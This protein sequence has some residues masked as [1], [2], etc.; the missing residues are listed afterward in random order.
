MLKVTQLTGFGSR[1]PGVTVTNETLTAAAGS[2]S[3]TGTAASL[4][5]AGNKLLAAGAGSYSL[6]GTAATIT[7]STS[8]SAEATAFL[9]R[10]SGLDTTHTNAYVALING[11]VA[12]GIWSKLDMLHVYATQDSTTALLNLVSTSFSGTVYG[13]PTFTADRGFTGTNGSSSVYIDTGFNATTAPSPKFT[14]NSGHVSAWSVVDVGAIGNAAIG[15]IASGYQTTLYPKF[16]DNNAYYRV[17]SLATGTANATPTG[18]YL[19]RRS[20]SSS[21]DGY[22]NGSLAI[23]NS[24][25]TSAAPVNFNFYTLA[26]NNNGT[27]AG[28]SHQVAMASIGSSLTATEVTNFYNRLRTYM[29]AVGVP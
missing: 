9:A 22:K 6:T 28:S 20:T 5:L 12:D 14:Q 15:V 29:T 1:A 19:A 10:T 23:N 16:T 4:R 7:K 17:N 24:S 25:T 11:L 27:A 2:Y 18:H 21:I 8:M 26:A 13:A 3:L